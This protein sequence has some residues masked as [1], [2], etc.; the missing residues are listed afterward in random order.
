MAVSI[1]NWL[2][3]ADDGIDV[4]TDVVLLTALNISQ[5]APINLRGMEV[6]DGD[7]HRRMWQERNRRARSNGRGGAPAQMASSVPGHGVTRTAAGN[8]ISSVESEGEDE[9]TAEEGNGS[10]GGIDM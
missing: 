3:G 8:V 10:D 9:G 4:E 1:N 5:S 6:D 7:F 2:R